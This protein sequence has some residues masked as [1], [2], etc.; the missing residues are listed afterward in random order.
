MR[1]SRRCSPSPLSTATWR[2]RPLAVLLSGL[3]ATS[4]WAS[5]SLEVGSLSIEDLMNIEVTSVSRKAQRLTDAAAAATV[6]TSEDIQRSGAQSI[7]EALRMVPGLD[8]ARISS[9]RWAVSARGFNGRFANKLLV[10]VDGRSVYSPFFSG[11]F[12]ESMDMPLE[13][14]ERIEVI[15]GPGATMWGANAVNGVINI[16]TRN[17]RRTQGGLVTA[18]AGNEGQGAG[19]ARWGGRID[20]D[21]HYRWVTQVHR[22]SSGEAIDGTDG[23]DDYRSQQ[24][25]FRLDRDLSGGSRFRATANAYDTRTGDDLLV[26]SFNSPYATRTP[27]TQI[28]RGGNVAAQAEWTTAGGGQSGLQVSLDQYRLNMQDVLVEDRTTFDVDYQNRFAL[29]E[30]HDLMWGLG[31]RHTEDTLR[32]GMTFFRMSPNDHAQDIFSGFVHDE[33]TLVPERWRVMLGSKF[34]HNG[35]TGFEVQPNVRTVW[36][37]NATDTVWGAVSRAVRTPSRVERGLSIDLASVPAGTYGN[38]L[39]ILVSMSADPNFRSESV[40]STEFG[41]RAQWAPN[42]LSDVSVFYNRYRDL[43]S[44]GDGT[45]TMTMVGSQPYLVQT[46]TTGNEL[47]ARAAGLEVALDWRISPAWRLQTAYTYIDL[48]TWGGSNRAGS[49]DISEG[50]SPR[51]QLSLR[52]SYDLGDRQ[53]LDAWIRRI[54]RLEGLGIDAYTELD[55]RWAWRVTPGV[56]LSLVGQNLLHD[57]HSEYT[58]DPLPALQM[59]IPRTYAVK[60]RWQF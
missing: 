39:P 13:D 36:N 11:T 60:V 42:L 16:L 29:N 51:N 3:L 33:I 5:E 1:H 50:T 38:P 12:W 24:A 20:D 58:A 47:Q 21:T 14:I 28:N 19:S 49:V 30:Q 43:R 54:G 32:S 52:S 6:I 55:L 10:L 34:E 7:P 26:A 22:R 37:L 44:G 15:R 35:Y 45:T 53:Q 17:T 27:S 2:V 25:G 48:D 9:S 23:A 56:E 8:V 59:R 4:A 18:L 46:L 40:V 41:Y 31:Y 57:Q